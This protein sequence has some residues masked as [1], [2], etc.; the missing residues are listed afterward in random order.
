LPG[1]TRYDLVLISIGVN[2]VTGLRRRHA[3]IAD[4]THTLRQLRARAPHC[5]I[6]VA[7]VPPLAAFPLLPQPLRALLGLRSQLLDQALQ[8]WLATQAEA[9]HVPMPFPPAPA[10]FAADGFHP[11]EASCAEWAAHLAQ[12]CL[13]RWPELRAAQ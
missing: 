10:R 7:A 2:D 5:R 4:L 13:A 12:A 8:R 9:L 6:V 11:N 1:D 3:F